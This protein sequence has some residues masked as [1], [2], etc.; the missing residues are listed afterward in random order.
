MAQQPATSNPRLDILRRE[1]EQTVFKPFRTHG[2]SITE[3]REIE[4]GDTIRVTALKGNETVRLAILYSSSGISNQQYRALE[5]Q[6]DHIFFHGQPYKLETFAAGVK[7]PVEPLSSFFPF[8]VGLNKRIEPDRS[9]QRLI[10]RP[11]T[12]KRLI[13]ESPLEAVLTRLQQFTSVNLAAKLVERRTLENGVSMSTD[14]IKSKAVGIAFSMRSAL[15]YI[16]STPGDRLNKRVL[17]LYYGTMAFAQA[18][19]LASPTGPVDLDEVEGMTKQGHGL[20][21]LV[22]P[23]GTFADLR[24]GVLATGFLPQWAS[25]LGHD[26][27]GYPTRKARSPS[28]IEKLPADAICSLRDLF[29]SIPEIDDLFTEVFNGTSNWIS[30]THDQETNLRSGIFNAAAKTDSTYGLFYDRSGGISIE[31]LN[32][33]G[34]PLA[35]IQKINDFDGAGVMYRARVDHVGHDIW[36][37]VLPTYSSPFGTRSALLLPTV[38][39]LRN[40][41]VIAAVTLYALSIMARYMPS[42]W[43]RI[44]GGDEDQYLAL[45][46]AALNVWER[47]LPAHFLESVSGEAVHTAQPG[48]LFS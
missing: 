4:H 22:G 33:A 31:R 27:S 47:V 9:P 16:V 23:T 12:V 1:V 48:S 13:A 14:V 20:Y 25:F 34:W 6:V 18:E 2:W 24:V 32:N 46:N 38:G 15:D 44:E 19:M 30:V 8:L 3:T 42:A 11:K 41:R 39:G 28:D 35:E 45:V 26:T 40:Y 36:W 7:I 17:G 5:N 10:Q 37:N 43:R 29:A 21:T